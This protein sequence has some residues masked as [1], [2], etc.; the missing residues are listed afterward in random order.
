MKSIPGYHHVRSGTVDVFA[1][2]NGEFVQVWSSAPD[3][4]F[5]SPAQVVLSYLRT[6]F[7]PAQVERTLQLEGGE[8]RSLELRGRQRVFWYRDT[9]KGC[10]R[11]YE[12]PSGFVL[13]DDC[14]QGVSINIIWSSSWDSSRGIAGKPLTDKEVIRLQESG[15]Y[16]F[17]VYSQCSAQ[18]G[19]QGGIAFVEFYKGTALVKAVEYHAGAVANCTSYSPIRE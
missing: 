13:V 18:C 11:E 15:G 3:G 12:L 8:F 9:N 4:D 2:N 7:G 1:Q 17:K 14:V 5:D 6:E 16:W 19:D 10:R